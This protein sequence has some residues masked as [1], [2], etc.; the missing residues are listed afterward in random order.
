M[1][2]QPCS[3]LG[4]VQLTAVA[5]PTASPVTDGGGYVHVG[6]PLAVRLVHYLHFAR[7][8]NRER[9]KIMECIRKTATVHRNEMYVRTDARCLWQPARLSDRGNGTVSGVWRN[10]PNTRTYAKVVC[11]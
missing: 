7:Q 5:V 10:A 3:K 4:E 6:L 11:S 8:L 1:T 2:E 9:K